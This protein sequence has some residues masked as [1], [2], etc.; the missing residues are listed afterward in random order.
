MLPDF[1]MHDWQDLHKT[2]TRHPVT[3][4]TPGLAPT[5]ADLNPRPQ[6]LTPDLACSRRRPV[7]G[8]GVPML[9]YEDTTP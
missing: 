8:V 5:L 1:C 3:M 9:M 4:L 6:T 2:D 7:T